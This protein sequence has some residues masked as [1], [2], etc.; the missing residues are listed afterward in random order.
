MQHAQKF[1]VESSIDFVGLVAHQE[2]ATLM[3]RARMVLYL[4]DVESFGLPVVEAL[5]A[6][7]PV[8]C[9]DLPVLREVGGDE[10]LYV[11]NGCPQLLADVWVHLLRGNLAPVTRP[12]VPWPMVAARVDSLIAAACSR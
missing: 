3:A 5:T 2:L 8:I 4:S 10:C 9:S 1:G 7:T 12:G 6:G 11:P